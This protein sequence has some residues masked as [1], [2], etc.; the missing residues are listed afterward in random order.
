[1]NT[2]KKLMTLL[3]GMLSKWRDSKFFLFLFST[4]TSFA[5]NTRRNN[6]KYS[7]SLDHW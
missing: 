6:H 3:L 4:I 5:T 7:I 2:T 1:M